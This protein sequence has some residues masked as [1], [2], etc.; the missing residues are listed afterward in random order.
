MESLNSH[1]SKMLLNAKISELIVGDFA[2]IIPVIPEHIFG[3][4]GEF[5]LIFF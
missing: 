4:V 5:E 1:F 3:H 2:I